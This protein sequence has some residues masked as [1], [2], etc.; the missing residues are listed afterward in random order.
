MNF[1][2]N[3]K[4]IIIMVGLPARGKS[5][6]S[7]NL[8]RYL[9]WCGMKCGVFNS[10]KLRRETYPN[11]SFAE[12]FNPNNS[13]YSEIREQISEKCFQNMLNW[14]NDEGNIGIFDATNTTIH[15]RSKLLNLIKESKLNSKTIFIEIISNNK[16]IIENNL[17]LKLM[18]QD[19]LHI[20]SDFALTDFNLRLKYY[21]NKYQEIN[22]DENINYIKLIKENNSIIT[23]NVYGAIESMITSYL[24]NLKINKNPIYI[25]RHGESIYN[26]EDRIG[27]DSLLTSKGYDYSFKLYE[28]IKKEINDNFDNFYTIT[29]CLK[30]TILTGK[31]FNTNNKQ[32]NLLNEING[33]ICEHMTY[34]E[35]K[36]KYPEIYEARKKN[37]LKFRY[38]QGES[39][40]DLLEKLKLFVLNIECM[41]TPFLIIAHRAIIR[42]L[43]AYFMDID[44]VDVPN[45]DIPLN[46]VIKL[47][48]SSD[49]YKL[50]YIKLII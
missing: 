39:Y 41:Q 28:F 45:I 44:L 32:C 9:S 6:T 38:P 10:G 43:L 25:S 15:R 3:K 17:K 14:L 48:P 23:H 26:T 2:L 18:S 27:G 40:L 29:S 49:K 22:N 5:Y 19:F 4:L 24:Q 1:A 36:N 20:S 16:S 42:I 13:T 33:G 21:E 7:N 34:Q 30:R 47:T 31:H 46:H 37:K 8:Q 11:S 50:E 12:F 35:V